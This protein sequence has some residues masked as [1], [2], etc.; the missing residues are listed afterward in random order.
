MHVLMLVYN[1]WPGLEGGAERQCRKLSKALVSRGVDVTVLTSRALAAHPAEEMD[2]GVRIVRV[3]IWSPRRRTRTAVGPT[4]S[5][6]NTPS[7]AMARP[8]WFTRMAG[9]VLRG[10][11]ILLFMR[12]ARHVI[13]RTPCDVIHV[14]TTT[15]I[16]GFGALMGRWKQTPVICKESTYPAFPRTP[17]IVPFRHYWRRLR[18]SNVFI[19]QHRDT[20]ISLERAGIPRA[21]I[22]IVPNGVNLLEVP[23]KPAGGMNVL[24]VGN[25]TQ[26]VMDKGLDLL[27]AAWKTV[28]I[29]EPSSK[30]TIVGAGEA[31]WIGRWADMNGIGCQVECLGFVRDIESLYRHHDLVVVPSRREGMSNVLL[32]AM[33]WKIPVV[34]TDIP[35]NRAVIR[36]EVSGFLIP[37]DDPDK[38]AQAILRLLRESRLK[39]EM[40]LAAQAAIRE[41]Y[42]MDVVVS[43]MKTLYRTVVSD[44][45]GKQN[46]PEGEVK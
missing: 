11:N 9:A 41:Q 38:M 27:T 21:R 5:G 16:A 19:A 13:K 8:H 17:P 20:A 30:L 29:A 24:F 3:P 18:R 6:V 23:E 39:Q 36:H 25:L 2:N 35:G 32:E 4:A 42:S 37:V 14:H 12:G 44:Y 43:M 45:S 15:W 40:G 10:I 22:H 1:Y 7:V 34:A 33:S 46:M 26:G 28:A 31:A